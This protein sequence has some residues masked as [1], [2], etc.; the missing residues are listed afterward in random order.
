MGDVYEWDDDDEEGP[1]R[2]R[3]AAIGAAVVAV[4]ALGWFVVRPALSD[5]DDGADDQT[6]LVET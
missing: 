1:S 2:G 6:V 3:I 4:A 5:D